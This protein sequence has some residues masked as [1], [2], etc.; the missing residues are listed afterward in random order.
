MARLSIFRVALVAAT[1]TSLAAVPAYAQISFASAIDLA[2]RSDPRVK[3]AQADVDKAR[4][5]LA[6]AHDAFIPSVSINGGYGKSTGVPLSVPVVFSLASQSLLFNFSQRDNVRAATSGLS[7]AMLAAQE[8]RDRVAEDVVVTYLNLDNV[9]KRQAAMSN[10]LGFAD[11]LVAIVQDRLDAGRDTRMELLRARR[12]AAQIHLQQLQIEEDAATLSNHLANI[13]GLPGNKLSTVS[14]S[15]PALPA[16]AT[17]ADDTT[18]S[19]VPPDSFGVQSAFAIA[20]SKEYIAFGQSRYRF[21][22]QLGF[23][24]NYS[25][26]DT[27]QTDYVDYYPGFKA[28]SLSAASVGIQITIP[29]YDRG[30]R[31]RAREASADAARALFDAQDQRNQFLEGRFKLQHAASV[32][33]ARAELATIDRDLAHEQLE[34][35]LVQLSAD[36]ATSTGPQVN[37]KDEQ[38][39]RLQEQARIIDLLEA[40][41]QLNQAQVNLMRQ[42]G[43]LESWLKSVAS[44]SP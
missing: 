21:R 17:L 25:R 18:A 33:S 3:G 13:I 29:L 15:V 36:G 1:L 27:A 40:E 31:D 30:Q 11:R 34:A 41:F 5:Q 24:A 20:K 38:N 12:T 4:A 9:Q 8:A 14:L 42:T 28:K 10:E 32:L 43:Q 19:T 2:L 26:I 16:I 37:P 6:A 7:A 44:G 35:V 23:G 39:A 22:P